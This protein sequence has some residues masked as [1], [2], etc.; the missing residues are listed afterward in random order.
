MTIK[1]CLD[2][3][4]EI[5]PNAFSDETKTVWLNEAEGMVQTEIL[6]RDLTECF[7]IFFTAQETTNITIPDD[8]TI[9]IADKRVL[10]KFRPGGEL[11]DF[12]PGGSYAADAAASLTIQDVNEDGL[13]FADGTFTATGTTPVSATLNYDGSNVE[14]LTPNPHSKIY[15][16]Y[17]I[18][19]IDYANG[20]YDKYD[21]TMQMFNA[22]WGE[23]SRWYARMY[24]PADRKKPAR[25]PNL[26]GY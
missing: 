25:E 21:N 18:A 13:V 2:Y 17:V 24:R 14:L 10:R 20:E 15:P 16:E 4:D 12:A 3:V 1:E 9:G 22:F 26:A 7:Q 11:T 8:H 19:R 5:K 6:L 23:Y